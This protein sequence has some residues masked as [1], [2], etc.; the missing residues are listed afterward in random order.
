MEVYYKDSSDGMAT[1]GP[2]M[3]WN[4]QDAAIAR[5]SSDPLPGIGP[6]SALASPWWAVGDDAFAM[7]G[8]AS[9]TIDGDIQTTGATTRVQ[10]AWIPES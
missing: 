4:D 7:A 2:E 6:S 1:W 9:V 10:V 3:L 8:G 5:L